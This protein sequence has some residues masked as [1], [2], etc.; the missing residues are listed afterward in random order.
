M[1][2][3]EKPPTPLS[4]NQANRR[5]LL[6]SA[7]SL[8]LLSVLPACAFRSEH[9]HPT[10]ITPHNNTRDQSSKTPNTV[11][12]ISAR[13]DA[14]GANYISGFNADGQTTFD[15]ALPERGHDIALSPDKKTAVALARRPGRFL[16]ALDTQS[17]AITHASSSRPDRHFYGHGVFSPDGRWFY[18]T[19]NDFERGVGVIGVR[20]AKRQFKQVGEFSSFGVGPHEIALLADGKTLVVANGGI[21]T[22]PDTGRSKLNIDDMQPSL[23]YLDRHTGTRLEQSFLPPAL[24]QNS[25]RHLALTPDDRVCLVMQYEGK[26][27]EDIPLIGLHQRGTPIRLL[28]APAPIQRRMR[29][30][31]GSVCVDASGQLFAVSSPHGGL[32]TFWRT[33]Q[34]DC[35]GHTDIIDGC[36]IAAGTQPGEFLLSSG[37]G[38]LYRYE[39]KQQSLTALTQTD[40]DTLRRWDNH[41]IQL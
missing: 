11:R 24:H 41:M 32:I 17:G 36:G 16:L 7:A 9:N 35:I 1:I 19:E 18:T 8:S 3:I 31:C 34:G 15:T 33:D 12:Y 38:G 40:H 29:Y 14:D 26:H 37:Q 6:V 5:R 20:D 27:R 4:P 21:Q 28:S 30:Y 25:I 23:V 2:K 39:A 22:H 13:A 10:A